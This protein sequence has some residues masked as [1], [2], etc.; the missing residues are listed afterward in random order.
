MGC[1]GLQNGLFENEHYLDAIDYDLLNIYDATKIVDATQKEHQNFWF[2]IIKI[3]IVEQ[4]HYL[5]PM[6]GGTA[7]AHK[8]NWK[9][10]RDLDV[11]Y[12]LV[13]GQIFFIRQL[14]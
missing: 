7:N 9:D 8:F 3:R 1:F 14:E 5:Y 10:P 2:T 12:R 4:D 6:I 13:Y 11:A